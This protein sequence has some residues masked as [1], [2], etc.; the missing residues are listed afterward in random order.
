MENAK[1][2]E[3][4]PQGPDPTLIPLE[5]RENPYVMTVAEQLEALRRAIQEEGGVWE[6]I[7]EE[8]FKRLEATAP[9]WPKGGDAFRSLRIRFGDG[10]K[11]VEQTFEAHY[12]RARR[13]HDLRPR[14][15]DEAA[16]LCGDARHLRLHRGWNPIFHLFRPKRE[17][18]AVVE[19]VIIPNLSAHRP[20][21]SV[22]AVRT[23]RSLADEGLVMIWMFPERW[24]QRPA[25]VMA[26]YEYNHWGT[27]GSHALE[28]MLG[29][30]YI[31]KWYGV[32][33]SDDL[34]N[35]RRKQYTD[36]DRKQRCWRTAGSW[37]LVNDR[38]YG[39]PYV[40]EVT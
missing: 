24:K 4:A 35:H 6:T 40:E 33:T 39:V 7:T 2:S 28:N 15:G 20:R 14:N 22:N 19:W 21:K 5:D 32:L 23:T 13:V 30:D 3:D 34:F 8:D 1:R 9:E 18:R 16:L 12:K 29:T 26:G 10:T 36:W 27:V 25:W 37:T 31:V 17:Y 11:G 38:H